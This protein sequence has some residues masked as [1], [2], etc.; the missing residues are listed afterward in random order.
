MKL[1][2]SLTFLASGFLLACGSSSSREDD[3]PREPGKI[4]QN[5]PCGLD[6]GFPGDE[7]CILP[8]APGEGIQIH[9]GPTSYSDE[10]ELADWVIEA[11]DENVRCFN[12]RVPESGFYYLGQK[13]RMRSGSHHMLIGLVPDDGRPEGPDECEITG[14]IGGI[15]GSQTPERDFPEELGPEDDGLARYIPEGSMA[16]FQLHYVNTG[17]ERLLREAWVNLY[18]VAETDVKQRLQGVFIVADVGAVVPA[19]S[20]GLVT[21]RFTPALT[22]PTRVFQLN[23]HMHA[24]AESMSVWRVRD[25]KK[26]LIY[27]SFDW[28]EPRELT[29]NSVSKNPAVDDDAKID[30]GVSGILTFEPGDAIEWTCD[31]NNTTDAP[32]GFANEAYTA[33]MCLLAGGY[34]SDQAGLFAG[35][36]IN[37][38]CGTRSF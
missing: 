3:G 37:G 18:K 5:D 2:L 36:C 22:E 13:S 38:K 34:I 25:E 7:Y 16:V 8:P 29:Y 20:R 26:E 33:E 32:L 10:A 21:N 9:A 35:V 1:A 28:A 11:G 14:R 30:G 12:A 15:P 4:T 17:E 19:R 6:S 31:V 24:H 23:A 27:K